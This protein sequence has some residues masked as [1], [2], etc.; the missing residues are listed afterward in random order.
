MAAETDIL[1]ID[2]A[3]TS[4]NAYDLVVT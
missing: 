1:G 2:A 3:C 4:V